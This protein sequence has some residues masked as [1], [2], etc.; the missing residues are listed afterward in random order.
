M[1][2]RVACCAAIATLSLPGL[3]WAVEPVAYITEIHAKGNADVRVK[4]AGEADW[5]APQPLLAL[6]PGDRIRASG[7]ARA[8]FLYHVGGGTQTVTAL[9]SPFTV[10]TPPSAGG[11]ELRGL[12]ADISR[13]LLGMQGPPTYRR[14]AVRGAVSEIVSPRHTRLFPG[15]LTFE[16]DGSDE[17]RYSVRVSGPEGLLWE[18]TN[19]P[20][21][22]V[23]YAATARA[24]RAGVRYA[25]ELEAPGQPVQRAHFEL[26]TD[27]EATRIRNALALLEPR[28][29]PGYPAGTLVLMRAA[30][31]FEEGLFTDARRE[32]E[33]EITADWSEPTLHFV[34]GRVYAHIGLAARAAQA[35]ERADTLA[36]EP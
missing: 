11:M 26:L 9:N 24:L 5:R 14:L 1:R 20:R 4:A 16:W 6:R 13:F 7:D 17:L 32:L 12:A 34:L 15:P 8:V 3:V 19:V 30:I 35:F 10:L 31:L 23:S 22:K 25:W 36:R 29:L 18:Q 2:W 27:A 28:S 21:Q 33:A